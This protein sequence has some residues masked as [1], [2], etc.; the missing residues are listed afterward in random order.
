VRIHQLSVTLGTGE[1]EEKEEEEEEVGEEE[2]ESK[3][4]GLQSNFLGTHQHSARAAARHLA[5]VQFLCRSAYH[6]KGLGCC[7][8]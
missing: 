5:G 4:R 8:P 3:R 2:T 7:S 1:E 6:H